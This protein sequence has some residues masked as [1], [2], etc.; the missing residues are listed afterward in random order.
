MTLSSRMTLTW[1]EKVNIYKEQRMILPVQ[2]ETP[3]T[4][5]A[6]GLPSGSHAIFH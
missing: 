6:T 5:R 3:A 4:R 2:T 1:A